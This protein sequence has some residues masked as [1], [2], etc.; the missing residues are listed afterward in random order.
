MQNNDKRSQ[1][2][3]SL[4]DYFLESF[5]CYCAHLN[6]LWWE[7]SAFWSGEC[8]ATPNNST[9]LFVPPINNSWA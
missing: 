5:Y 9:T 1:V 2:K 6:I 8:A 3:K 4:A 7:I